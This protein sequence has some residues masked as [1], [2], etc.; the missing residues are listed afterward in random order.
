MTL[1]SGYWLKRKGDGQGEEVGL[2]GKYGKTR[3]MVKD[4]KKAE[5]CNKSLPLAK[6][7]P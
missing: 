2:G 1:S 4:G 5:G 6:F 7:D 3:R